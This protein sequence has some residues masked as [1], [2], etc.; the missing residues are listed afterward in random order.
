MSSRHPV[1]SRSEVRRNVPG[2]MCKNCICSLRLNWHELGR[3][4]SYSNYPCSGCG[5]RFADAAKEALRKLGASGRPSQSD[6]EQCV[7]P[8]VAYPSSPCRS[9]FSDLGEQIQDQMERLGSDDAHIHAAAVRQLL[10]GGSA[11]A[12]ALS[13]ACNTPSAFSRRAAEALRKIG[14]EA[15]EPLVQVLKTGDCDAQVHA[16]IGLHLI[17]DPSS[18]QPLMEALESPFAE[19]RKAAIGAL[20]KLKDERAVEPLIRHLQDE[21]IDVAASAAGTLGWIGDRRVVGPLLLALEN[22]HWRLRQ[23]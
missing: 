8:T 18:L 20:W 14:R 23:A 3:F 2:G 7:Q 16:I 13:R 15:V 22:R 5:V 21:D 11:S 17:C 10:D 12:V 4:A 1:V 9:T 19:V 6:S